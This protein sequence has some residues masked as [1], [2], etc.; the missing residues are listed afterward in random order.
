MTDHPIRFF[1]SAEAIRHVGEGLLAR[2]LNLN[3]GAQP[4]HYL[5]VNMLT[6]EMIV[7]AIGGAPGAAS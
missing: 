7:D 1:D 6:F 3:F 2:T 5:A 4:D